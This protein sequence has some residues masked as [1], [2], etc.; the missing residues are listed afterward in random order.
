MKTPVHLL[1]PMSGQGVRYQKAGYKEPKPLIPVNGTPMIERLLAAFPA[2]WPAH[3]VLAENHR[4]TPLPKLLKRLRPKGR[5][6]YVPVHNQGPGPAVGEALKHMPKDAPVFISY[7]DYGMVW[8]AVLFEKFVRDAACDACVVSYRGFHAHYLNPVTYAYSRL[9]GEN[10]AE[11]R[12]KGSFTD[13]R[14]GE[15]ASSGGY[16]FK[17]ASILKK[18]LEH[19]IKC[20]LRVNGELYTSLTVQALLSM[21]PRARVR[22]FEIPAF[23]QWGTPD[24]L[25]TFVYWEKTFAAFNAGAGADRGEVSQILMPMAGKGSRFEKLFSHPKPFIQIQGRPIF[26]G[27]LDSLPR[28]RKT[29]L[30]T[31]ESMK[32]FLK[33]YPYEIIYLEET[34]PGQALSTQAGV[35]ALDLDQDVI[36]SAC[37]H[38]VYFGDHW[39]RF[40]KNPDCDAAIFAIRGFPGARRSPNAFAYIE[41]APGRTLFQEVK[42]VSVKKPLSDRPDRDPLLVGTFWFR[43]GRVLKEGIES[44]VSE[45]IRVNNELYL[46]SVFNLLMASGKKVR[47]IPLEGYLNWG[48]PDSLAEALYWQEVWGGHRLGLRPRFPGVSG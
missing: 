19:Q 17:S 5:L 38:A 39:K 35:G 20:G 7:C 40:R 45:N 15:F 36:V 21:N 14:E 3:F 11:V 33:D 4:R 23:F 43:S 32:P 44:L 42:S 34:P 25:E 8:D 16:Y 24:D 26:A 18:A 9:D 29:V 30:V 41:T 37:D 22:V 31:L 6:H 48:D 13:N 10:V 2:A 27:A 47:I 12:E 1:V 46:D 28:A